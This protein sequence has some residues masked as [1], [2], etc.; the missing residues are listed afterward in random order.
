MMNSNTHTDVP[1]AVDAGFKRPVRLGLIAIVLAF[2]G[3]GGWAALAPLD[4][5]SI[6]TG[7]LA[8]ESDR[9]PIQHLQGGVIAEILVKENDRVNEGQSLFRLESVQAKADLVAYTAQ[10]DG[11][12]AL[13]FRLLAERAGARELKFTR[14]F[15]RQTKSHGT[16]SVIADQHR[17]FKGHLQALSNDLQIQTVRIDQATRDL[18]ARKSQ[19]QVLQQQLDSYKNEAGVVAGLVAKGVYAR[20]KLTD[21]ER[22]QARVT[23]DLNGLQAEATRSQGVIDEAQIQIKQIKQKYTEDATQQLAELRAKVQDLTQKITVA[24]DVLGHVDIRAPKAGFVQGIKVHSVGAVIRGG[25][26]IA[27]LVTLSDG[28]IVTARVLPSDV[29]NVA[30]GQRSEIRFPSMA[31]DQKRPAYGTLQGISAD[32]VTDETTHLSYYAAR[33]AL[34]RST[35]DAAL[36][37]RLIPGMPADVLIINGEHTLLAYLVEPLLN[38]LSKTLRD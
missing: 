23:G 1:Q 24:K 26:T 22:N 11:L 20:A 30:V 14:H 3:F 2:G 12:L 35:L 13:K 28:L 27:D 29:H 4:S 16:Y 37:E 6:A 36:R 33:I 32:L 7:Q 15:V 18:A 8:V 34:D 5:A 17:Q 38:R 25:E 31:H 21:V 19:M 10:R 9:K